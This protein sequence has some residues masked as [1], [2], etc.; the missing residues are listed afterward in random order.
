[1][2]H[3][4][5]GSRVSLLHSVMAVPIA[6]AATATHTLPNVPSK[7]PSP[8]LHSTDRQPF[9][10]LQKQGLGFHASADTMH[11]LEMPIWP[12]IAPNTF[13]NLERRWSVMDR[14][15]SREE[16]I[17]FCFFL[18]SSGEKVQ[19]NIFQETVFLP[20]FCHFRLHVFRISVAN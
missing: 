2:V 7:L 20:K 14:G 19:E 18:N 1:M 13:S 4:N 17:F 16:L 5:F 11:T 15:F 3:G 6:K 8:P 12:T 9:Y 10:C